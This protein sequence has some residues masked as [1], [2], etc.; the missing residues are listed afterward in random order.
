[1]IRRAMYAPILEGLFGENILPTVNEVGKMTSMIMILN[2]SL[3]QV[4]YKQFEKL[5]VQ[6]DE[7]FEY[8]AQ[9]PPFFIK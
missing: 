4:E 6:F 1:M 2:V 8:A 9:I 5:F 3:L 7:N